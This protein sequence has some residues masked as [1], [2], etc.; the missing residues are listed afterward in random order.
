MIRYFKE[1]YNL[2]VVDKSALL[3]VIS[4]FLR[5]VKI[6]QAYAFQYAHNP[7]HTSFA[8]LNTH[9]DL[10]KTIDQSGR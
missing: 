4:G 9:Y 7:S 10:M 2:P 8:T 3:R 6:K 5:V 1:V